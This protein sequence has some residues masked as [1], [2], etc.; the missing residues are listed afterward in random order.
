M[1]TEKPKA[2]NKTKARVLN[3]D[4][5]TALIAHTIPN[6]RALIVTAIYTGLRQSELLGLRWVD[7]YRPAGVLPQRLGARPPEGR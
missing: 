6:Y 5:I 4:Q 7:A 3:V 2:K 1:R